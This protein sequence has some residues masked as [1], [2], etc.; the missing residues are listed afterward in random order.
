MISTY[1]EIVNLYDLC[2]L[3]LVM[4]VLIKACI[5]ITDYPTKPGYPSFR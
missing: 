1:T 2:P 5:L 3:I 4:T